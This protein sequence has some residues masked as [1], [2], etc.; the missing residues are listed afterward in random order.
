MIYIYNMISNRNIAEST[1]SESVSQL[2][3]RCLWDKQLPAAAK[4]KPKR[5]VS[6]TCSTA[7]RIKTVMRSS[8]A[9]CK[10]TAAHLRA[11]IPNLCVFVSKYV[12]QSAHDDLN[13]DSNEFTWFKPWLLR[14]WLCSSW[15]KSTADSLLG[16]MCMPTYKHACLHTYM[17]RRESDGHYASFLWLQYTRRIRDSEG[18]W[19]TQTA[20]MSYLSHD[21]LVQ[22]IT[23]LRGRN[24]PYWRKCSGTF[25]D[26]LQPSARWCVLKTAAR[27]CVLK[28][29]ARWCWVLVACCRCCG[30][31]HMYDA[32]WRSWIL[33]RPESVSDCCAW[34]HTP[35]T[36]SASIFQ[37]MR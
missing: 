28:T 33:N 15:F 11:C 18:K 19:G 16:H 14:R 27:W 25:L 34:A 2:K 31:A 21:G 4:P 1:Y 6:C 9:R 12:Y 36:Y 8:T 7:P 20:I 24:T 30:R 22:S 3:L 23:G 13:H 17:Y 35:L 5:H 32:T 26:V 29:A 37:S 10:C